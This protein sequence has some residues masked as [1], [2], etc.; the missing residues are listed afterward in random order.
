MLKPVPWANALA[1]TT[2]LFYLALWILSTIAPQLFTLV[3]NAQFLGADVASL[4]QTNLNTDRA[5]ITLIVL[6]ISS[7]IVGYI[8]AYL[9]NQFLK[10]TK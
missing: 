9:Y 2:A 7:W 3:F 6:V 5:V 10:K 8:W 1:L 4:Y